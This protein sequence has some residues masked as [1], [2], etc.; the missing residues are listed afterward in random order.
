MH[1][2]PQPYLGRS[3]R[4]DKAAAFLAVMRFPF[5]AAPRTLK[6]LNRLIAETEPLT[7]FAPRAVLGEGPLHPDLA[8]VGEQ[9]GDQE[10]M[11]GRPFVGPAGKLLDR[12]L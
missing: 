3:E 9:P 11:E 5:M 1:R 6:G 7:G 10:E 2:V 12:A 8:L 4:Q